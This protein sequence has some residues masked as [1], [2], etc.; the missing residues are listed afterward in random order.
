[1]ASGT[2]STMKLVDLRFLLFGATLLVGALGC[3]AGDPAGTDDSDEPTTSDDDDSDERDSGTSDTDDTDDTDDDDSK[4]GARPRDDG[5]TQATD[6]GKPAVREDASPPTPRDAGA[7]KP[8]EA[9]TPEIPGLLDAG[10]TLPPAP[11]LFGDG[12]LLA[13]KIPGPPSAD[14]VK[15]CPPVAPDNPIGPCL[16]V[17]VYATCTYGTYSCICDWFHWICI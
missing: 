13:P 10:V 6:S 15:E 3:S 17:P 5:G 16:G 7:P 9:G 8:S 11:D 14:N 1:V 2:I 12:G 4:D